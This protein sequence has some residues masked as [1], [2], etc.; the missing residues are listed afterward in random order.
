M[1]MLRVGGLLLLGVQA[2]FAV[3]TVKLNDL[4]VRDAQSGAI[5]VLGTEG[6]YNNGATVTKTAVFDGNTSSF[7]DPSDAAA[8]AGGAWAGIELTAPKCCLKI[9]YCVR[10]G[11]QGRLNECLIQGANSSDFSDAE[12]IHRISTAGWNGGGW[13]EELCS[14]PAVMKAWKYFRI[15]GPNPYPNTRPGATNTDAGTCCGNCAELEFY[16]CDLPETAPAPEVTISNPSII[17]GGINFQYSASPD[18]WLYEIQRKTALDS[19]FS[20][21][22]YLGTLETAGTKWFNAKTVASVASVFRIRSLT[23][24]A[25][26]EWAEVSFDATY[27]LTGSWIGTPGSWATNAACVGSVAFDGNVT[28]FYDALY[29]N[30]QW[31]GLDFGSERLVTGVRFV[32][33]NTNLSRLDGGKFQIANAPDF[34]DAVTVYTSTSANRPAA[35]AVKEVV[36]DEPVSGRYARYLAPD[37]GYGNIAEAE[38]DTTPGPV[39]APTALKIARTDLTNCLARLTWSNT[40]VIGVSSTLVWRATGAG[41]PWTN[42]IA[43]LPTEALEYIDAQAHVGVKYWYRLSYGSLSDG[44]MLSGSATSAVV[45]HRRCRRLE[46][47]WSDNTKLLPGFT[48]IN[49]VRAWN[50]GADTAA[51]LFDGSV[52]TIADIVEADGSSDTGTVKGGVDLG[53]PHGVG[54]FRV[55]PRSGLTGRG[56]GHYLYGS[57]A[58][59]LDDWSGEEQVSTTKTAFSGAVWNL[60]ECSNPRLYRKFWLRKPGGSG[61]C[62]FSELELYGWN[63]SDL[64]GTL[65]APEIVT[66]TPT[67]SGVR[68][69]WTPASAA[70]SYR[71]ERSINDAGTF[72][73]VATVTDTTYLDANVQYDGHIYTYRVVS[74]NGDEKSISESF[75]IIPYVPGSGTGLTYIYSHRWDHDAATIPTAVVTGLISKLDVY[76]GTNKLISSSASSSNYVGG[77]WSGSI[78]IPFD[79]EYKFVVSADDYISLKIGGVDVYNNFS[80]AATK[81]TTNAVTLTAGTHP[82]RVDFCEK[83]GNASAMVTWGGCVEWGEIPSTQLI[84]SAPALPAPWEG[85]RTFCSQLMGDATVDAATGVIR[86]GNTGGDFYGPDDNCHCLWQRFKGRNFDCRMHVELDPDALNNMKCML[87]VRSALDVKAPLVASIY[88]YMG[89]QFFMGSA[90][91]MVQDANILDADSAWT[92]LGIKA[93]WLRVVRMGDRFRLMYSSDGQRWTTIGVHDFDAGIWGDEVLIGPAAVGSVSSHARTPHFLVKDFTVGPATFFTSIILR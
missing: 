68:L 13:R 32:G 7:F 69:E 70:Q 81:P 49:Y 9:R 12:T 90:R 67:A 65:C 18:A 91:R 47:D 41:G 87:L 30:G 43:A 33:R 61:F 73:P 25:E 48:A 20:P 79:G 24:H 34:S 76:W 50:N 27:P 35:Y 38:F 77:V 21:F 8:K 71:V 89:G 4:A 75:R 63:V 55:Y 86:I 54:F 36:F 28:T 39:T 23:P 2:G 58:A 14:M 11:N 26:S 93:G 22:R 84:P 37:Q 64:A 17:N 72:S 83:I 59:A 53:A 3:T 66:T 82:I 85:N 60:V 74:I 31:T 57:N 40:D 78:V 15:I 45:P 88:R 46:R 6:S 44:M 42:L 92:S 5:V 62:N 52:S 80:S 16:G 1:N 19:E 29:A 10:S 56:D 51:H